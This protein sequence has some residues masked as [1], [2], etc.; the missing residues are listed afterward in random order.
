VSGALSVLVAFLL[1]VL[2]VS[3]WSLNTDQDIV[4]HVQMNGQMN[5]LRVQQKG[6]ASRGLLKLTFD[7]VREIEL[8]PACAIPRNP[9]AID[10]R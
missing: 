4:V 3:A 5:V 6:K 9:L 2:Q 10:Q 7:N 8:V 1:T